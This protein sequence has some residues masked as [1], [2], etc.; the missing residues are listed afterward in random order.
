MPK[1]DAKACPPPWPEEEEEEKEHREFTTNDVSA[2]CGRQPPPPTAAAPETPPPPKTCDQLGWKV[3]ELARSHG[4][5]EVC[6]GPTTS[7]G[8]PGQ[9]TCFEPATHAE[10][11]GVPTLPPFWLASAPESSSSWAHSRRPSPHA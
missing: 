7:C 11:R 6:G 2:A 9:E 10:Q 1:L 8:C 4:L 3:N 5:P